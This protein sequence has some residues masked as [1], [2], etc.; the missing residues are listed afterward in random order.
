MLDA[1]EG[2]GSGQMGRYCRRAVVGVSAIISTGRAISASSSRRRHA[3]T[4][5]DR[6]AGSALSRHRPSALAK[7]AEDAA[8]FK[9]PVARPFIH[10]FMLG[11]PPGAACYRH[12]AVPGWAASQKWR[13]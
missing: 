12:E 8:A 2:A 3:H 11:P 1:D 13:L 7:R 5:G 9:L 6:R 10:I 4:F